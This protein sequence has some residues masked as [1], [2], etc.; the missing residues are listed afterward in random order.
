MFSLRALT[1]QP[2]PPHLTCA[3]AVL[4]S[5]VRFSGATVHF[6]EESYDTGPVLAQRAVP[7]LPGDTPASLAARVLVQVWPHSLTLVRTL[8]C[9]PGTPHLAP[10]IRCAA[11]RHAGR[12]RCAGA[13][14]GERLGALPHP[15]PECST[16]QTLR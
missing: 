1:T 8:S 2:I 4:D 7:V 12:P 9:N 5:G 15:D 10:N 14:A 13:R 16:V 6:V 11:G 3:Q